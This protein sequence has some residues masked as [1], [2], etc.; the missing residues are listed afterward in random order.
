MLIQKMISFYLESI[1]LYFRNAQ[2]VLELLE[3]DICSKL[4]KSLFKYLNIFHSIPAF[5]NSVNLDLFSKQTC[6]R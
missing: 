5:L 2:G 6:M 1:F 4:D 3:S